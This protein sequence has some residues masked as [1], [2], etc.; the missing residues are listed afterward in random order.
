MYHFLSGYT[1]KVAGTE[2]GVTEPQATFSACFGAAFLVWHPTKYAEM[3]ADRMRA[4]RPQAWLVNTG[5]SGGAVRHRLAHQAG[6]HPGDHRCHSSRHARRRRR[7]REDPVFGLAVPAEVPG[8][9]RRMLLP[10]DTWSDPAAYDRM[11]ERL[12]RL[13]DEHFRQFAADASDETRNA[14]PRLAFAG[15]SE[16]DTVRKACSDYLSRFACRVRCAAACGSYLRCTATDRKQ[17]TASPAMERL[18]VK[19]RM[20]RIHHDGDRPVRGADVPP[21]ARRATSGRAAGHAA[22]ARAA[23]QAASR[24]QPDAR[25]GPRA[26]PADVRAREHQHRPGP[27]RAGPATGPI[28]LWSATTGRSSSPRRWR[29]PGWGASI[30]TPRCCPSIAAPRRSIGPSITERPKPATR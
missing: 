27:R 10:R 15:R 18:C 8:V 24:R 21:V 17:S 23:W 12:S 14:G 26:R 6:V 20:L 13:F 16:S 22:T 29:L 4:P 3:L 30:C 1:A 11:A 7:R 19:S 5:W 2:M 25:G 28:C 9:P